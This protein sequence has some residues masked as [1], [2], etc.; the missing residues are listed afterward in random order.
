ME[1]SQYSASSQL[2]AA[3]TLNSCS[4]YNHSCG[5]C[6]YQQQSCIAHSGSRNSF[7]DQRAL[8]AADYTGTDTGQGHARTTSVSDRASVYTASIPEHSHHLKQCET[9]I[10]SHSRLRVFFVVLV[11]INVIF[12]IAVCVAIPFFINT[13]QT[14]TKMNELNDRSRS[15]YG[16]SSCNVLKQKFETLGKEAF[17]DHLPDNDGCCFNSAEETLEFLAEVGNAT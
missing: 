15:E 13:Y 3:P 7:T 12:I 2:W 14:V 6:R 11:G 10:R 9:V 8:Y 1:R 17:V 5:T 16:C 4:N